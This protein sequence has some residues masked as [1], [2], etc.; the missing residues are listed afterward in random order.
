MLGE[1]RKKPSYIYKLH[2]RSTPKLPPV[3]ARSVNQNKLDYAIMKRKEKNAHLKLLRRDGTH[4]AFPE[5]IGTILNLSCC[6]C[7]CYV[8]YVNVM[9]LMSMLCCLH[10]CHES[11]VAVVMQFKA[12]LM[13]M[14]D[15][16]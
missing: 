10:Q 6:L 5:A 14:N 2:L 13:R 11:H 8:A 7:Q 15:A 16:V 12:L 3:P 9:L 4:M 1:L